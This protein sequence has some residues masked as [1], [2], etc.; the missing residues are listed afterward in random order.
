MPSAAV[1]LAAVLTWWR[2][3]CRRGEEAK[4]LEPG[5]GEGKSCGEDEE[6]EVLFIFFG[7]D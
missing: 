7:L 1:S 4:M 3:R 5:T 6:D 2:R